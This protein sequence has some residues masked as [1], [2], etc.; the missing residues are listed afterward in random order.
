MRRQSLSP[1]W[2]SL[3]QQ[4]HRLLEQRFQS[5]QVAC[6][7]RPIQGAMIYREREPQAV[8]QCDFALILGGLTRDGA[9]GQDRR[10]WR[11]DHRLELFDSE[12]AQVADR[13]G[14]AAVVGWLEFSC[15][16]ALGEVT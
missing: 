5:L 15:V 13:E 1:E 3:D 9:Y 11:I 16:S 6:A 2:R 4:Q 10:F 12:H 14:A 7:D 8:A